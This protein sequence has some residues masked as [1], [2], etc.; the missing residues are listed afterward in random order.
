MNSDIVNHFEYLGA[1]I[2]NNNEE[3]KEMQKGLSKASKTVG[4]LKKLFKSN[5]Q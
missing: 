4:F 5:E 1:A 2:T 3:E